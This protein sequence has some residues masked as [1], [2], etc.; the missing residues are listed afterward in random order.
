[1]KIGNLKTI[2]EYNALIENL[3]PLG[4]YQICMYAICIVYW[5]IAGMH[6]TCFEMAFK[7]FKCSYAIGTF[8]GIGLIVF[9][10]FASIKGRKIAN[11]A[12]AA[13]ALIGFILCLVYVIQRM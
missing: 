8:E 9:G 3:N 1:M 11:F 4:K 2:S 12:A 10:W 7:S 6:A 13:V 5:M